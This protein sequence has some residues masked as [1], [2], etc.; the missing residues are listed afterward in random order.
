MKLGVNIDHAATIRQAR[1]AD[2]PDLPAIA[3]AAEDGGADFIT[4]H[5]REDR[6]HI[7]DGDLPALQKVV[8]TCINL[9]IA[10]VA[11]MQNIALSLSPR[12]ACLVPERRAELTTEGG[13]DARKR[14]SALRDFCTPLAAKGIEVSLFID[15]N[16]A[17]VEAA[18][19]I[20]APAIELHT[21]EYARN[22]DIRPLQTAAA[23]AADCGLKV[24]A[25]H[26]LH[27]QNAA[28]VAA[29]P[30]IVELNIGH[31]IIAR[32]LF[33]GMQKAVAEMVALIKTATHAS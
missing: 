31:A 13:L 12:K 18:A 27:L 22:G 23:A 4:V 9:E 28:A 15:P 17:Q 26:G 29:I 2:Y 1:R 10:A 6:R 16:S 3:R 5:L 11:E 30:N 20:G 21:G 8:R 25:G 33:V 32:A 24:H 7:T 14:I 19:Q